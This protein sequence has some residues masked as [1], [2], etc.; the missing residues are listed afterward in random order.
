MVARK[1]SV[2]TI[3]CLDLPPSHPD[4]AVDDLVRSEADNLIGITRRIC[5]LSK[6]GKTGAATAQTHT[7]KWQ[8]GKGRC[9]P[10]SPMNPRTLQGQ[11]RHQARLHA[12]MARAQQSKRTRTNDGD[13]WDAPQTRH[14]ESYAEVAGPS[15]AHRRKADQFR[16]NHLGL[17]GRLAH[18]RRQMQKDAA[19]LA[20][21]KSPACEKEAERRAVH[22]FENVYTPFIQA[23]IAAS[24]ASLRPSRS[25]DAVSQ[26]HRS[27][28]KRNARGGSRGAYVRQIRGFV[29]ADS[30]FPVLA[31]DLVKHVNEDSS[32]GV[33]E[34]ACVEEAAS[35]IDVGQVSSVHTLY[36][37]MTLERH[38]GTSSAKEPDWGDSMTNLFPNGRSH[39]PIYHTLRNNTVFEFETTDVRLARLFYACIGGCDSLDSEA[40]IDNA[41]AHVGD[42]SQP[43]V[44]ATSHGEGISGETTVTVTHGRYPSNYPRIKEVTKLAAAAITC[45][46]SEAINAIM[47]RD[48]GHNDVGKLQLIAANALTSFVA[49]AIDAALQRG[50]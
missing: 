46:T 39:H 15:T 4:F 48:Q 22:G 6:I 45:L 29:E 47:D 21:R 5:E 40:Y 12:Q 33:V 27:V 11:A 8:P 34:V 17:R 25:Q 35:C 36:E 13:H 19:W 14:R 44:A 32:T 10:D 18:N 43:H 42:A 49:N 20:W 30:G 9:F 7:T 1:D 28:D 16:R 31:E 26:S 23:S 50:R 41:M 37:D 38:A 2:G 24:A 3:P